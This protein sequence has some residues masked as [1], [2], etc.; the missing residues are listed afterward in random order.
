MT[1]PAAPAT[2]PPFALAADSPR[3]ICPESKDRSMTLRLACPLLSALA[4]ASCT[5]GPPL[6][7]DATR[8]DPARHQRLVGM[9]IGEVY[10]PGQ[11]EQR[12]I[13][14]GQV[15]DFA[16]RPGRLNIY[17]DPKGWIGRVSCE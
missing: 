16:Y 1:R 6:T 9:N 3:E 12:I 17:V 15:T 5:A 10:L 13:S 8:C 7:V 14:P 11:L 2:A 4:L